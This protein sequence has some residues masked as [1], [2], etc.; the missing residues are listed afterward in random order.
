V[1]NILGIFTNLTAFPYKMRIYD[2]PLEKD[3]EKIEVVQRKIP[4]IVVG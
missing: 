3:A 2:L 4:Y 1:I